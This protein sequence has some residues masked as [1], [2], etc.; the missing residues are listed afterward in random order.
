MVLSWFMQIQH[1][2]HFLFGGSW[3]TW[4][5]WISGCFLLGSFVATT[6]MP[7]HFVVAWSPPWNFG[8]GRELPNLGNPCKW[9]LPKW[10]TSTC[11]LFLK[12]HIEKMHQKWK[13]RI[14]WKLNITTP[15]LIDTSVSTGRVRKKNKLASG[16]Q[17]VPKLK[18]EKPACASRWLKQEG[19]IDDQQPTCRQW[20]CLFSNH[21]PLISS[22]MFA[23]R[24]VRWGVGYI[25]TRCQLWRFCEKIG[26]EK[27]KLIDTKRS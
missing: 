22:F 12:E 21:L 10:S 27:R 11:Q 17:P 1:N 7:G 16:E 15:I 13:C 4:C 14:L 2:Q 19:N 8:V 20:Q 3:K 25:P 6:A 18:Q 24:A 9:K 26:E 23:R 5:H